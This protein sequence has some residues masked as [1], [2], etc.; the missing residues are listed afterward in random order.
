M[1]DGDPPERK[2]TAER[3]PH[4]PPSR[5]WVLFGVL[6][7]YAVLSAYAPPLLGW[8]EGQ[9]GRATLEALSYVF[10]GGL[11]IWVVFPSV[12]NWIQHGIDR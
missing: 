3:W 1:S 8:E 5:K 12:T 6:F 11:L 4:M 2:S 7:V 10:L 9:W